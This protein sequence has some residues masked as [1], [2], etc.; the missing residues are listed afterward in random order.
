MRPEHGGNKTWPGPWSSRHRSRV[1]W[2]R[3][4]DSL[5][6][7][8]I[9]GT[10]S[11]LT[12]VPG[13]FSKK[14]KTGFPF[15]LNKR[16]TLLDL[17]GTG[18]VWCCLMHG[19]MNPTQRAIGSLGW[20]VCSWFAWTLFLPGKSGGIKNNCPGLDCWHFCLSG[21]PFH[22]SQQKAS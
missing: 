6:R 1:S 7:I 4:R 10:E 8:S 20:M 2:A 11:R 14:K 17:L 12:R 19:I 21:K 15:S 3:G 5:H 22:R 18:P 9:P 16:Q 13:C